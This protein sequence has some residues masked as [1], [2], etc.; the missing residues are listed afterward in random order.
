MRHST[1]QIGLGIGVL[2]IV[3]AGFFAG[4]ALHPDPSSGFAFA[5]DSPAYEATSPD[6]ALTKGGFSGFGEITGLPGLTLLS[7]KVASV[8]AQEVVIEAA[9]G[10]KSSVRLANPGAVRRFEAASQSALVSGATVVLRHA[11]DGDEVEAV[12]VV[13]DP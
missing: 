2:I 3:V 12:L 10:T 13:G 5:T 9:D 7:G 4:R 11:E 8:S 6:P 1:T